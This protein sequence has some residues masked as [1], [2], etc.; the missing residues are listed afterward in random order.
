MQ[1]LLM[2]LVKVLYIFFASHAFNLGISLGCS[3]SFSAKLV[4]SN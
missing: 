2:M 1:P 4:K 3:L